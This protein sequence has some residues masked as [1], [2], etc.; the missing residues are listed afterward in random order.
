MDNLGQFFHDSW[1]AFLTVILGLIAYF[2]VE[3]NKKIIDLKE[4]K[5]DKPFYKKDRELLES[6]LEN[7]ID[8]IEF[9]LRLL[10]QKSDIT[11]QEKTTNKN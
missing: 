11:Y 7:K 10:C 5:V 2:H 9:H 4:G 6:Q 1:N 8:R 3:Q